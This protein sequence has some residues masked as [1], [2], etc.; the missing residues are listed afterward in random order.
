MMDDLLHY[1]CLE[2]LGN[3]LFR[4]GRNILKIATFGTIHLENPTRFQM[5][6]VAIFGLTVLVSFLIFLLSLS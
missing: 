3:F 5:F 1:L 6:I 4:F 2:I